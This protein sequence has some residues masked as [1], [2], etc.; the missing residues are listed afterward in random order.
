MDIRIARLED[1]NGIVEVHCSDVEEWYHYENG[2][3]RE[4]DSYD[5][6]T[7][8]E[9]YLHGGPWMSIE[10]RAIHLNNLLLNG[11]IPLVAE[12]EGRIIGELELF[13]SEELINERTRKI[14]HIDVL[15]VHREFR[16]Q[17]I[18]RELVKA[19][20][21][22]ARKEK[23]ELLT[24][25]PEKEAVKFYEK[26]GIKDILHKGCFISFDLSALPNREVKGLNIREFSWEEV[27]DK[28]MTLGKFQSSYHHWF[29]AFKDKIAGVDNTLYF[30]SGQ[31]GES[32]YILEGSFFGKDIATLY[33]WGDNIEKL[34]LQIGSRAKDVGFREIR[35]SIS[36]KDLEKIQTLKPKVLDRFIILAK[37]L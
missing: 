17:G 28:E 8:K 5:N 1:T 11:Q 29:T 20:E 23:C 31:I 14:A 6:L 15:E 18:G 22:L 10:T 3:R 36:E 32:Y 2:Q 25:T 34:I 12:I 7:L 19:A 35:T 16:G 9:R 30:E 4:P 26:V 24:V 27:K 13:I 21:E 37:T 33:A